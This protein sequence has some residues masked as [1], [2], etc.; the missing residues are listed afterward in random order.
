MRGGKH[1]LRG[2]SYPCKFLRCDTFLLSKL[3][4][5]QRNSH[6]FKK[7]ER[8]R[9]AL[10]LNPLIFSSVLIEENIKIALENETKADERG[11]TNGIISEI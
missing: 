5:K 1:V 10:W 2:F 7:V 9:V 6:K 4:C 3:Q 8:V 11:A